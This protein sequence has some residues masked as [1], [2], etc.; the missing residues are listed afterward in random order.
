MFKFYKC[1]RQCRF[2]CIKVNK[3]ELK[4]VKKIRG[5]MRSS[6]SNTLIISVWYTAPISYEYLSISQWLTKIFL[7]NPLT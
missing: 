6:H 2:D 1:H 4:V 3:L 5:E 7:I